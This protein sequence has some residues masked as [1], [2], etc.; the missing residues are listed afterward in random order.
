MLRQLL[1]YFKML[2]INFWCELFSK[3]ILP[4]KLRTIWC[5]EK[6]IASTWCSIVIASKC[7]ISYLTLSECRHSNSCLSSCINGLMNSIPRWCHIKTNTNIALSL[8]SYS[9]KFLLSCVDLLYQLK[10][11]L[12]SFIY[13]KY[14]WFVT[15]KE[16]SG[17]KLKWLHFAHMHTGSCHYVGQ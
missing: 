11:T 16:W 8:G 4:L 13:A 14:R 5:R 2:S 6:L 10:H 7:L 9:V 1:I 3:T 12:H 15:Y 17:A